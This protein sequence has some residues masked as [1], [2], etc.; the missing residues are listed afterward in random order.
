MPPG[1]AAAALRARFARIVERRPGFATL[2]RLLARLHAREAEPSL[3]VPERPEIPPHTNGSG[4]DRR[5][6]VT[7]RKVPGGTWSGAG[8]EARDAGL[9]SAC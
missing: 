6:H 5:A 1:R 2:D 7:E 4:N 8:R 3:L 9:A